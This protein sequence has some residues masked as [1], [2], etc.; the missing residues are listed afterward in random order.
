MKFTKK[1]EKEQPVKQKE[2]LG[3]VGVLMPSEEWMSYRTR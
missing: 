3:K 1:T 2:N